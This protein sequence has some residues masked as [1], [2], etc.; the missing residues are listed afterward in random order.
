[1]KDPTLIKNWKK[2]MSQCINISFEHARTHLRW[3]IFEAEN[4]FVATKERS[5]NSFV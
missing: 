4:S 2:Y 3:L 5:N 1:M